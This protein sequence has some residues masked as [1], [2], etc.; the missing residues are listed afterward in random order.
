MSD[1]T[2]E[3]LETQLDYALGTVDWRIVDA[4]GT[5]EECLRNARTAL[6]LP[7]TANR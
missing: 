1:A 3:I 2:V 6:A 7:A 5:P 4:S